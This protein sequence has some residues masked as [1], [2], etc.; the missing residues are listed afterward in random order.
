MEDFTGVTFNY[1]TGVR[2]TDK[3]KSGNTVWVWKCQCGNETEV[4]SAL[5]KNGHTKSCGCYKARNTEV[6]KKCKRCGETSYRRD[7][8]GYYSSI[9]TKCYNKQVH[10]SKDYVGILI[11]SARVRAKKNG[12]PFTITRED[13]IIPDVCPVFGIKLERG[14]VKNRESSPSLDK[15]I[16]ELGYVRGNIA[17]ISWLA[18][19]IKNRGT[20]EQHRRIADW[21]DSV[22]QTEKELVAS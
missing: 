8:N 14:S 3:R 6:I 13:V 15:L 17:V 21:M 11:N 16:P 19:N 22:S 7:Q 9:C 12:L 4:R 10:E 2:A 1:L 18:N 20:A 5:V